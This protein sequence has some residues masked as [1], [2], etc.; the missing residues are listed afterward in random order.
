M[1]KSILE[2]AANT[3]NLLYHFDS[4]QEQVYFIF[5]TLQRPVKVV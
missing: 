2:I 1:L 4:R 5:E 3:E